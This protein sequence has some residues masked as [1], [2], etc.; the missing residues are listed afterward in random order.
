MTSAKQSKRLRA[1]RVAPPPVRGRD[2]RR[3]ASPRVLLAAAAARVLVIVAV[4]LGVV[5]S[6][7]GSSKA[8]VPARG[9]LTNGLPGA[10]G[11][12]AL[13]KGIAQHGNVLGSTSA[14]VT[15]VEYV[16]LQC[17]YCQQFETQ[18]MT[19]LIPRYVRTGKVK[20]ELRTLAFIGPD[21]VRG[22]SAALAAAEQ[23]KLFNFAQ[24]LF[25]SQGT[26]NTGWLSDD[27]VKAAAASIPGLNVP[28]LLSAR[29]SSSVSEQA[30]QLDSRATA[31]GVNSTPTILVGKSGTTPTPVTLSSLT[32]PTAVEDAIAAALR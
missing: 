17:P 12:Q 25:L 1:A 10:A 21:S 15:M 24:L 27:I 30:Q 11:V 3:Q 13:L 5:L 28:Q 9:S 16:D 4:V 20:V 26:E 22:R 8:T 7:E 29:S 31:D 23:N 6:R 14:P 19:T 2:Q 32:D 18:A